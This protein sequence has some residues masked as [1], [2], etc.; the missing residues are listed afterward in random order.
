MKDKDF[1]PGDG[2]GTEKPRDP[3]KDLATFDSINNPLDATAFAAEALPYWINRAAEAEAREGIFREA[4]SRL[5][6]CIY[7]IAKHPQRTNRVN[8]CLKTAAEIAEAAP[9]P[10]P[11]SLTGWSGWCGTKYDREKQA[12]YGEGGGE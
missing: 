11:L 7:V 5:H 10:A 1:A 8:E 2:P 6:G 9:A 12:L 3:R 4:I